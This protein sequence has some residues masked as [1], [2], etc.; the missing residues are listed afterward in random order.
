MFFFALA[1]G[2]NICIPQ[3][4]VRSLSDRRGPEEGEEEEEEDGTRE[5]PL[6][7]NH[8]PPQHLRRAPEPSLPS[9][10][11]SSSGGSS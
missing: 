5:Y 7:Y 9:S 2:R 4:L 6:P 1:D 3:S 11:G 8:V 10:A